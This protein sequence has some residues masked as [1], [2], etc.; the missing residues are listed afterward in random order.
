MAV[1][2]ETLGQFVDRQLAWWILRTPGVAV[3]KEAVGLLLA[4]PL[5]TRFVSLRTLDIY[6]AQWACT[7]VDRIQVAGILG[8]YNE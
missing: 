6:A 5:R 1:R 4:L 2:A 7:L 8:T 3:G